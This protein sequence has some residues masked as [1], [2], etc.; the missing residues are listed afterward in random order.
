ML[1]RR[2]LVPAAL[3]FAVFVALGALDTSHFWREPWFFIGLATALSA[4]FAEP[5][6]TRPQ[7]AILNGSA[8]I[9]A[10]FAVTRDPIE[11]LWFV[12]LAVAAAVLATGLF[13]TLT[14]QGPGAG[15]W[16]AYRVSSRLGRAVVLGC[17]ALLLV[18]LTEAATG[19]DSFEYLALGVG[20]FALALAIDWHQILRRTIARPGPAVAINALGPRRLELVSMDSRTV[21][22]RLQLT[23]PSA[24]CTGTITARLPGKSG[25]HYHVVLDVDCTTLSPT[26]P[27]DIELAPA[28]GSTFIG[29]AGP[30]STE[31]KIV[32]EPV[33]DMSIGD[34]V[35]IDVA[36]TAS[37]HRLPQCRPSPRITFW[38]PP[39]HSRSSGAR[40]SG[41]IPAMIALERS[42][43]AS[44]SAVCW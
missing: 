5:Y 39:G 9:G 2:R 35:V 42:N 3:G 26:F 19:S 32:F 21:G 23:S 25:T 43:A 7:D 37:H 6:F 31:L 22:D 8:A 16:L 34:P 11:S 17:T 44:S 15:K 18:T 28:E 33:R 10:F 29:A 40:K 30:H 36:R 27:T 24:S 14:V 13:A 41:R 1:A 20:V 4:T 12:Y 38:H